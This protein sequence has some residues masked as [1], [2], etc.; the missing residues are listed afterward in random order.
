MFFREVVKELKRIASA[1][2]GLEFLL[3]SQLSGVSIGQRLEQ[4]TQEI[5]QAHQSGGKSKPAPVPI[6]NVLYAQADEGDGD[7]YRGQE[8]DSLQQYWLNE[9]RRQVMEEVAARQQVEWRK[10]Q[11]RDSGEGEE[12]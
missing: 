3:R 7:F 2:E 5:L 9:G 8:L 10:S 12:G 1:L 11:L 6:G 4:E